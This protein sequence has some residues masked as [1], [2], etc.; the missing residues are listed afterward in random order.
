MLLYFLTIKFNLLLFRST[1]SYD[2]YETHH[3]HPAA[4][5]SANKF[6]ARSETQASLLILFYKCDIL[7]FSQTLRVLHNVEWT[8]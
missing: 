7:I 2:P 8:L 4:G 1:L 5:H 3:A 6:Q